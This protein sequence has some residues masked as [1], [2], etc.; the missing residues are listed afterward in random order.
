MIQ[1]RGRS[2]TWVDRFVTRLFRFSGKFPTV[3]SI[4][5]RSHVIAHNRSERVYGNS[6]AF[7]II[8]FQP[9]K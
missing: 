3:T 9:P 7:A 2:A 1:I 4:G 6:I 5:H 8:G